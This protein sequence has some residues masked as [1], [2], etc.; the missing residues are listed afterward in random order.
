MSDADTLLRSGDMAGARAALV[1]QVKSR[2]DDP[3]A[4]LYLFQLLALQGDWDK[5]D[6]HLRTLAQLSPEA[7]MLAIAYGQAIAAEK[8][9]TKA[10]A[11]E[12]EPPI[13]TGASPWS[14][15][16]ARAFHLISS[17]RIDEGIALRDEAFDEVPDT[18]GEIDGAAFDWIGDADARLGPLLEAV[19]AGRWGLVPIDAIERIETEGPVDLRDLVWLPVQIGFRNGQSVAGL[20][21]VRYPGSETSDDPEVR[22]ARKTEWETRDWGEAGLGQ[23]L[24][25]LSD[26]TDRGILEMRT[27]TFAQADG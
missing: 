21:P 11:G 27:M 3:Q 25:S 1:Q 9:R 24:L 10:F 17:G 26:G 13:L 4:R 5:A 8:E 6:L 22:M 12:I 16:L 14:E 2:P 19:I 15:K 20:M 18:P 23:H 7:Q